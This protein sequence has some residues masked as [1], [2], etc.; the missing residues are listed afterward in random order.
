MSFIKSSCT[1]YNSYGSPGPIS[2]VYIG[3]IC[4]VYGVIGP[5]KAVIGPNSGLHVGFQKGA[6]EICKTP[7]ILAPS[8]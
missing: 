5:I 2:L 6:G 1:L 7:L 8:N 4:S 3:P